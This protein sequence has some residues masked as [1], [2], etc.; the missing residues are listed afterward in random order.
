MPDSIDMSQDELDVWSDI[1]NT[2]NV[3]T[4]TIGLM[5]IT[6]TMMTI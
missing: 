2:N 6:L 1:N 3:L 4:W 5:L